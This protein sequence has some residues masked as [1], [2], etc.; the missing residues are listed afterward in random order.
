M[1]LVAG[2][3][4]YIGSHT[5]K[6]LQRGGYETVVFDNLSRGH[7][8]FVK[9]GKFIHGD[10]GDTAQI[11]RCF[12]EYPISAVMHFSAFAYV[13]ESVADPAIYYRNNL[14][15]TINLLDVMREYGVKYFIFSSTCATYGIPDRMPITE[16]HPQNPVNPYGRSKLMVE[17][18]LQDYENA[19]G[20]KH[21]NLRYFNAAGADPEGETGEWHDPETH[22]IPLAIY[23]ALRRVDHLKIFGTDYPTKDGT[24]IRDYI[25]VCDLADAHIKALE[26]LRSTNKSDSFNLGNGN[27]YSVREIIDITRKISNKDFRVVEAERREGDPAVLVSSHNKAEE[28]LKWSP[29]LNNIENIVETAWRWHTKGTD[30]KPLRE[31]SAAL[32]RR[33]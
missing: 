29:K 31:E 15:N 17:K 8:E 14:L 16:D 25:H 30:L 7:R 21:V 23:A 3:A 9:W 5:N 19:Y 1:I 26:H 18:V 32:T 2:G 28:I 4:G 12:Q 24:C 10:L 6:L 11:R 27:G 20:I 13:G 22:L 33:P